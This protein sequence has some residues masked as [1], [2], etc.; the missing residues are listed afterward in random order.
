MKINWML[1]FTFPSQIFGQLLSVTTLVGS[2]A[3]YADGIGN[4]TQFKNPISVDISYDENFAL[5]VVHIQH[6]GL[7]HKIYIKLYI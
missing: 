2:T 3:G 1:L 7:F 5:V 6:H 4:K